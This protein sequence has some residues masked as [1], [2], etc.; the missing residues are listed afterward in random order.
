MFRVRP[1]SVVLALLG[2]GA[3]WAL[4]VLVAVPAV[5]RQAWRGESLPVLN[6]I[7]EGRDVHPVE[8]YIASWWPIARTATLWLIAAVAAVALLVAL[9]RFLRRPAVRDAI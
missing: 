2:A 7:F 1:R 4:I 3:A 9:G 5:I 8:E 6:G